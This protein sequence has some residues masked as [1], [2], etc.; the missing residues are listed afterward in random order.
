MG[1][2]MN[3]SKGFEMLSSTGSRKYPVGIVG[4]ASYQRA[5]RQCRAG[6]LV[7]IV[8]ELAN[9]YDG[10]ALAVATADGDTIGY[11]A[12][13]CWLQDA[14]HEE[15]HGCE[16]RIKEISSAGGGKFGVVLD[17][18]I[19]GAAVPTRQFNRHQSESKSKGWLARLFGL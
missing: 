6:Q 9:P 4:E 11:I 5:I 15:G 12:R 16:A 7:Q 1:L 2:L 13:N 17:V 3:D 18:S 14:V 8:H 10:R 19:G